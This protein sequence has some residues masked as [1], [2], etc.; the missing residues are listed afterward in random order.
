MKKRGIFILVLSLLFISG[1][2]SSVINETDSTECNN[3]RDCFPASC[4]HPNE[5][6]LESEAPNCEGIFC[7][8]EC[9]PSTLDCGQGRCICENNECKALIYS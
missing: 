4:C 1:C 8:T 9:A 2:D 3:D 7:T 5:C 6:V